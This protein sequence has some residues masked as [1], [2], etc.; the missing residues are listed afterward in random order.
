MKVQRTI[1]PAAATLDWA[2]LWYGVLGSLAGQSTIDR[3]EG[4]L[5]EYFGVR[6]V[7]A[8]SSG[9]AALAVILG[10]LTSLSSRRE[11]VIPAYTC[12]SVPSAICKTN[13]TVRLCDVDQRTFDFDYSLL[14]KVVSDRT[15]CVVPNHLFGI[16]SDLDRLRTVCEPRG[17]Y[18]IED[19]AQAMGGSYKGR[20]LG[21][22]GDAGFFSFGRG[23]NITCGSGGIIV[24][25]SSS[26]SSMIEKNYTTL[27]RSS[28]YGSLKELIVLLFAKVFIHPWLYWFP[29][30]LPFLGLGETIFYADF[31]VKRFSG[32]KAGLMRRWKAH[33]E[34]SNRARISNGRYF[35]REVTEDTPA[36][37]G[38]PYLRF[39]I[40]AKNRESRDRL[41]AFSQKKGVG[42]STMY[43]TPICEIPEIRSAFVGERFPS[44]TD[45][46]ARI[47]T[48][49]THTLVIER[50]RSAI[51]K[52]LNSSRGFE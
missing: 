6:Y 48:I 25:N 21:T 50:D 46:A 10:A 39:P 35:M 43:P 32:F 33:L 17:I 15:L 16:P 18:V 12:F 27:D 23:K 34:E 31:P 45:I 5:R 2:D 11:V 47:L 49:P 14:E 40:L 20:K 37:N 51:M 19:A 7:Y 41:F 24:T 22:I 13:L 38:E 3:F 1:P 4:E 30:G 44:A 26:I 29:A 42:L 28:V 9:K 36:Q 8:V 52:L